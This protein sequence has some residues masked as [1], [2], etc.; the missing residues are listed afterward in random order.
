MIF[1]SRKS[2]DQGGA[3]A[4]APLAEEA[5]ELLA[6]IGEL[7]EANRADRDPA[8]ERRLLRLRHR[9]GVALVRGDSPP[10]RYPEPADSDLPERIGSDL[11]EYEPTQLTPQ[12]L[13][14]AILR[15]G[16]MLV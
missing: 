1:R 14:A 9:A 11:P 5:G 10:P 3:V 2:R 7:T 8:R 4:E 13:R 16:C 15:D 12:M 6:E